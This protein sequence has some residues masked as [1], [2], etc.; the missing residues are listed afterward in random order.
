MNRDLD[1]LVQ[2]ALQCSIYAAPKAPGL[3]HAEILEVGKRL[4]Y[5]EGELDDAIRYA[6]QTEHVER[7]FGDA[8]LRLKGNPWLCDF[9][10]TD[11]PDYRNVEAFDYVSKELT[12]LARTVGVRAAKIDR[13]VLVE[14]AKAYSLPAHDVEVA[15]TH[16]VL[17]THLSEAKGV[18]TLGQQWRE[19]TASEQL[20]QTGGIH[21]RHNEL[22][23]KLLPIVR[24]VVQRRDDGR[25][26]AAEPFDA[27]AEQL[28]NLGFKP[29]QLWWR[30]TVAEL[31]R[32]D[33]SVNPVS[34]AVLS[35]AL[36]EAGL[37]FVVKHARSLGLGVFKS[38]D[39]DG[40]PKSWKID[41]LIKSA[42]TGG[43]SA[44]IDQSTKVRAEE[45]CR[46]RQRIHAGRMLSDHPS[47]P[48]DL[49]PEE[50]RDAKAT[51]ELVVRRVLD[52]LRKYPANPST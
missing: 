19:Q 27:F 32:L 49:R 8:K 46:T 15:I 25:P 44:V 7:F 12:G 4:G 36:V 24:D 5:R 51:A 40:E 30:Q 11:D 16:M 50:A 20:A 1:K 47:G 17:A 9:L 38:K 48:T 42:A 3:T 18:L 52:W 35:A 21:R 31:Q 37:T 33:P 39:F 28:S 43:E 14:R 23:E 45:L 6:L 10:L 29:F 34:S 13:A 2:E 41:D 22:R 26:A